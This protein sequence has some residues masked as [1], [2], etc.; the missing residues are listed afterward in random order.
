MHQVVQPSTT[1]FGQNTILTRHFPQK[2][3]QLETQNRL[4]PPTMKPHSLNLLTAG[5]P[6]LYWRGTDRWC[7]GPYVLVLLSSA[8]VFFHSHVILCLYLRLCS[9]PSSLFSSNPSR[10]LHLSAI[11][12]SFS[13]SF[14]FLRVCITLKD[15]I[16][17]SVGSPLLSYTLRRRERILW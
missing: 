4:F 14:S 17:T 8:L 10:S 15:G 9:W 3:L 2:E 16:I 6:F 5:P 1:S 12:T 13:F 11:K 7:S